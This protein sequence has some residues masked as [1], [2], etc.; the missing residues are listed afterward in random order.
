MHQPYRLQTGSHKPK[1]LLVADCGSAVQGGGGAG[2]TLVHI[3]G[4][5]IRDVNGLERGSMQL[6]T[7]DAA[8]RFRQLCT[9]SCIHVIGVR[10]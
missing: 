7:I 6:V 8:G 1:H 9:L 5:G 2:R 4:H 3:P 10:V